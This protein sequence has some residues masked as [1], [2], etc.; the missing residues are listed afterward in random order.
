MNNPSISHSIV[1]ARN[2][3]LEKK[4]RLHVDLRIED[5]LLNT[6]DLHGLSRSDIVNIALERYLK[7]EGYLNSETIS[8]IEGI[9]QADKT[10]F[11]NGLY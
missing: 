10:I 2:M 1:T 9:T 6:I 4:S 7:E 11:S 8:I 5:F 3:G